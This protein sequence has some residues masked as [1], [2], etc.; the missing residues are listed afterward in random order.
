MSTSPQYTLK[1]HDVYKLT[2]N[3]LDTL[4]LTMP[5]AIESRDLLRVLVF[6]AASRLSVHQACDQ[7][8]CAPS[9][10][11][12]LGTL[13]SQFSDLDALEG[14]LNDLLAKQI[15]KG[16]GK[17][18]RRVAVDLVALPYHGTVDETH[19]DEV[20]RSKAKGG[21]THFFTYATAYAVVRGR[22]YTLAMCRVRAK[23]TMDHVLHTL[24]AR[25]VTL[26]IR[27]KLVLLDR[28]F[29]S[30]RV[31]QDLITAEL[32]F[33]LPAVKRGKKP[34]TPG[35]PTGTYALAA[36]KHSQWTTYTLKSAKE[37]QVDFDL[38]V[39]CHNTRG[40]RGRHQREALLYA[41]W[42]VNHR[43]M[44]WIRATYR[45]RF[46][47]ES[48]YRQLHQ[49]RIRTS[50][51]KPALR[52]LFMGVALV[53][54][55]VWV[56]LHAEVMAQP[57]RG[58]RK[59]RPQSLHF[60]RVLLWLMMEVAKHDSLLRQIPVYHHLYKRAQAFGIVFNY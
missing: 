16:L 19:H 47:I 51:R 54:R 44:S 1:S 18:G 20:C 58:A 14:H 41:T 8:E 25:V 49:A 34:M 10:P 46:G 27:I 2:I 22:R 45:R 31:I 60:A 21:T 28:G 7:L 42:G 9:G 29:Y 55:N 37:G 50:S 13:A 6:A 32:P 39:V 40:Q 35:G 33:I 3:T 57:Q 53:L 5:G 52:L 15:P 11:T 36:E 59:L 17:R 56:W 43:P 48:S 26:G 4:P 24:L 30:V 23:Q 38:A 12:V